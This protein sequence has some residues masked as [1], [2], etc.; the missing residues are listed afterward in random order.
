MYK[1]ASLVAVLTILS[2]I[3]GLIRD[4]VITNYY[5]TSTISDA[6][7]MAYLFTGNFFVVF[8]CIGGP[9]YSSI[10]SIFPKLT[11]P[12]DSDTETS[13]SLKNHAAWT[14]FKGTVLKTSLAL[15]VLVFAIFV[16]KS[17]ILKSFI[18]IEARPEYYDLTVFNIDLLLP[19]ILLCGPIGLIAAFLNIYKRYVEP[20]ISP[21]IVNLALIA[22]VFVMGDSYNGIALALGT[23]VGAVL[24]L[25]FQLPAVE[26][27]RK[28][29]VKDHQTETKDFQKQLRTYIDS[30]KSFKEYSHILFPALLSTALAQGMVFI[31]GFFCKSL[32]EGSWTALVIA[33]R[34]IQMP[35]G[36]LVT[37]FLVPLFPKISELAATNQV[38]GIKQETLKAVQILTL[39]C[40]PAIIIGIFWTEP[41]IKFIFERGAFDARSTNMLSSAF[42]ILCF[43]IVPYIMRDMVTR[44]FFSFGDS[45]T[46]FLVMIMGIILKVLLNF[47]L[48]KNYGLVGIASATV[49]ITIVNFSVLYFI[50][51][52]KFLR[53]SGR[54]NK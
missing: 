50:A 24:S 33:N 23:S 29:L 46:P 40:L 1:V 54:L 2:K 52:Y 15:L 48:V 41:L 30:V 20:S 39:L 9:F 43:S 49:I 17:Y 13:V 21:A 25:V 26:S 6:F 14:F 36:V 38:E 53:P 34:L 51:N 32:E 31:D 47:L 16:L 44:I 18:D 28:L 19:L 37:S 3:S 11:K 22:A 10:I 27:V 35:L 45:K 4:L 7:N 5:G 42:F 8:G 12:A